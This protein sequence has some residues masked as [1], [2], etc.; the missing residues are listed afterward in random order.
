MQLQITDSPMVDY[1]RNNCLLLAAFCMLFFS[2]CNQTFEPIQKNNRYNF[3]ISGY[4]DAS[5]D[6][7]WVRVGTVRQTID[8][9]PDPTGIEVTLEHIQSGQTTVMNDSVFTSRN[10]LNYWTTMDI[11]NEQ[12]YRITA[13][14]SNGKSSQVTVTTPKDLPTVFVN[15]ITPAPVEARIYI[16]DSI[17]HIADI[18]SVWYVILNPATERLRRVYRFPV[19]NTLR[20]TSS[21]FGFYYASAN[22]DEEEEQILQSVGSAEIKIVSRQFF[23][24]AGG[25]EWNDSLSTIDD[26]EY[27]INGTASNVENGLG[28]VV[29]ISSGWY[30][31][32][33]CLNSDRSGYAPCPKKE[34][35]W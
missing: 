26:L 12:S 10:V 24:A 23:V 14:R 3:N 19:R 1:K 31:Q 29:G 16:N 21:F 20:H 34:P 9:L 8:E 35:F 7:Q 5:A 30:Q 15:V 32:I 2:N 13:E 4:L 17:E 11:E 22:W 27:F 18:Q 28:Y 6:T 33:T 25:P